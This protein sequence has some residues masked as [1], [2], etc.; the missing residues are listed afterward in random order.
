MSSR[1]CDSQTVGRVRVVRMRDHVSANELGPR[2][3]DE[4]RTQ[5]LGSDGPCVLT[6]GA[7]AF[8]IGASQV[9]G[10][11]FESKAVEN[12]LLDLRRRRPACVMAVEGAVVGWGLALMLAG[13]F[14]VGTEDAYFNAGTWAGVDDVFIRMVLKPLESVIGSQRARLLAYTGRSIDGL[15]ALHWGLLDHLA[16]PP[17]LID[18][19]VAIAEASYLPP[20]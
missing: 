11:E 14:K 18:D 16:T 2:M 20:C 13:Q 5:V 8:S 12:L 6:G 1:L 7:E 15:E 4:L 10:A 9:P 19:A 17:A 3:V